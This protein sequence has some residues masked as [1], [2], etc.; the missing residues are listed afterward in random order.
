MRMTT[1]EQIEQVVQMANLLERKVATGEEARQILKIGVWY[2]SVEETL[3]NI[4]LPPNRK[5]GQ[6]GF[7]VKDTDGHLSEPAF[8]SCMHPI[9]WK[10]LHE[11]ITAETKAAA[12][13]IA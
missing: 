13:K 3:A 1:V 7:I 11:K 10:D 5:D 4:A 12:K 6:L 2:N 9:P 8:S